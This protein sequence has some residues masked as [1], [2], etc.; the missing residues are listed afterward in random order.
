MKVIFIIFSIFVF[1]N[2]AQA[3]ED[4]E[5]ELAS[6]E[7]KLSLEEFRALAFKNSPILAEIDRDYAED[8]AKA[9]ETEVLANPELEFEQSSTSMKLDGADDTQSNISVSQPLRFSDFGAREKVASLIR[10]AGNVR[11]KAKLLEFNQQLLLQFHSLYVLQETRRIIS[12][13]EE[14]S[15]KKVELI[16]RGVVKGLLSVGDEKLFEGEKYRLRAQVKGIDSSIFQLQ[17]EIARTLGSTCSILVRASRRSISLDSAEALIAKSR[18]SNL[19]ELARLNLLDELV[20]EQKRLAK[21]NSYPQIT[22]KL[23]YEHTNDGGDFFGFGISV[24]LPF[25]N[26][27][28]AEQIR[29]KAEQ[30]ILKKKKEFLKN[31]G[32][33]SQI[34]TLREATINSKEQA[35]IFSNKVL[36]SFEASLLSQEK[37]Y[38]EGKGNIL[39]VWQMLRTLNDAEMQSLAI[40][41]DAISAQAKLSLLIGEEL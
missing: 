18:A 3:A 7:H 21:L 25:W 41:F 19:S 38:A 4:V 30:R 27:N 5:R 24:P 34:K 12:D 37:L 20:A 22:P 15:A 40:W 11:K 1:S 31:G 39:Q 13:A 2:I 35:E 6:C 28:Q 26:R 33:E 8:L 23:I 14:R 10:K 29:V 32:F 36:P 16:R 9:F 17:S